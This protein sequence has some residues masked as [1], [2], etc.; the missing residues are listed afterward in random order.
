MSNVP[1]S[2][3]EQKLVNVMVLDDCRQ[4]SCGFHAAGSEA[5]KTLRMG[6]E[7]PRCI[8]AAV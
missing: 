3:F 2:V 5:S 8:D 1:F 6:E 7:S 4:I